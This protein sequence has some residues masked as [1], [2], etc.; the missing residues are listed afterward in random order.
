M[1]NIK[2]TNYEAMLERCVPE[3]VN[4]QL[5]E[6]RTGRI[7]LASAMGIAKILAPEVYY[8]HRTVNV[9]GQA[10]ALPTMGCVD[11]IAGNEE[12]KDS[13]V[14]LPKNEL[15]YRVLFSGCSA[16]AFGSGYPMHGEQRV[17]DYNE[18]TF[19]FADAVQQG[20]S[21]LIAA[22]SM[23]VD[24]WI[25]NRGYTVANSSMGANSSYTLPLLSPTLYPTIA[26]T[27][28]FSNGGISPINTIR[29]F[30]K[31][32]KEYAHS[33]NVILIMGAKALADFSMHPEVMRFITNGALANY[34]T[35]SAAQVNALA[36]LNAV[37][38]GISGYR[39]RIEPFTFIRTLSPEIS[40]GVPV[41]LYLANDTFCTY[42]KAA[43]WVEGDKFLEV[44]FVGES[45]MLAIGLDALNA[46]MGVHAVDSEYMEHIG[47][48]K[49][50]REYIIEPLVEG[51]FGMQK[52]IGMNFRMARSLYMNPQAF[53]IG[54]VTSP[55]GAVGGGGG[56]V[57]NPL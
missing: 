36:N 21:G 2:I 30:V 35:P 33:S 10:V 42:R 19:I 41:S 22:E 13:F 44:P 39:N 31:G 47:M 53:H 29:A 25:R 48:N 32:V 15:A 57:T 27:D 20:L 4:M 45:E 7:G 52:L 37:S 5:I 14:S 18:E 28:Y 55:S 46:V 56:T 38:F 9:K 54:T 23:M 50:P 43:G 12:E 51:K 34:G 24:S 17:L 8:R 40:G 11:P 6:E 3:V 1:S 16:G 26:P 49:V